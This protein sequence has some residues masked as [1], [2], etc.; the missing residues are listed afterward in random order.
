MKTALLLVLAAGVGF[1]TG[2]VIIAKRDAVRHGVAMAE[3]QAAF[4]SEK[5]ALEEALDAARARRP[6]IPAPTPTPS[7]PAPA[8][9]TPAEIIAKLQTF[10]GANPRTLRE[11]VYWLTELAQNGPSALPVIRE[12]LARNQ[13]LDWDTAS[14]AQGRT[15]RD[16]PLDF[17][18]PPSL[19]FGLFDVVRQIGGPD[20]EQILA[21]SLTRTGRG[22]EVA[23]LARV[24]Q[25]IAPNQYKDQ[26]LT[27]ARD[28]LASSAPLSSTSP[29]DR[30][31]RDYLYGVL[32]MYNDG[33]FAATAQAQ[34][35]QAD[36]QIDRSA[37]K[38]LQQVLG[39]QSV[40]I[41]A[42]AYQ[43]PRV[44]DSAKKE[45][46]ARLALSFA[47][48]DQQANEFYNRAINDPV[49]TP[50]HRKNL[51]EDLNED[52]L[53]FRNLTQQDLP[54][55]KNRLILIDQLAPDAMDKVNAA[56]FQEAR[57]D[58]VNMVTRLENASK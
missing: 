23:Y 25:E 15:T 48:A 13:D 28:L 11:A 52:G 3:Q 36:G 29:L 31:H 17:A 18:L 50:S 32:A 40:A 1:A 7:A 46:L 8:R 47:G 30:G 44:S 54:L 38:Y 58:L 27:V 10:K 57:K 22:V 41:A 20:A 24:L 16:V 12:F 21:E 53:N 55:I 26:A 19:R 51:I 33:S 37:L 6:S 43:D 14:F 49:M 35:V 5:A 42:Q 56:A 45:P 4:N 2:W 34:L 9:P 39:P